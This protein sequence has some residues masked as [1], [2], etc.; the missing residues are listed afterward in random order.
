[1]EILSANIIAENLL[2]QVD[3]EGHIN[4]LL[5]EIVDHRCDNTAMSSSDNM[6]Q[7]ENDVTHQRY[8]TKGWQIYVQWKDGSS[9][10]V[11]MKDIKNSYPVELAEYAITAGIDN[12][13]AFSWWIPYTL[14]ER[15]RILSKLKSKYWLRIHKYGCEIPKTIAD[16]KRIDAANKNTLWQD[17]IELEMKNIRVAFEL[18]NGD[19]ANLKG[20]K[21]VGTHLIFDI[22]LGGNFRR[23]VRCVGDGHRTDTPA[24]VTYSSV[25]SRD[26]VRICLLIAALNDLDIKCADIKNA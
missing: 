23:K 2:S 25:V 3:S 14:T 16:A 20:Y 6:Y 1:M 13:P 8:T 7:D 18:Y 5:D 10:W 9:I 21:S 12:L 11:A 26:S 17:A 19:P 24:S 22:K 15:S 4:C